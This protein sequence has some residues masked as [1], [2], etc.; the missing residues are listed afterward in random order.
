[1][2]NVIVIGASSGIGKE[3]AR[4][5][6][7]DKHKV[8]IAGRRM[9]LLNNLYAECPESYL[10][11]EIDITNIEQSK[12]QLDNI[13]QKLVKIDLVVLCSGLGGDN[14]QLN[15]EREIEIV[16][17]NVLGFTF[18][19]NWFYHYFEKQTYGHIAVIT[20]IAGLRGN[21]VAPGYFASK[22]YQ[23]AYLEGLKQKSYQTSNDIIITDIRP[24]FVQTDMLARKNLPWTAQPT[25]AAHQIWINIKKRRKTA[26]ITKRWRLIAILLKWMPAAIYN[27]L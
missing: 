20:S 24:G 27:K 6:K 3:L 5:I 11:L 23:I 22:A 25:K 15:T 7:N 14:D 18:I 16:K 21:R 17:T 13:S 19:V 10:P 1:M 12:L 2:K 8:V 26:Y 4:Q 9:T